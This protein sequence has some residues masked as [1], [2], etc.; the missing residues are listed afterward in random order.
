MVVNQMRVEDVVDNA[1]AVVN[2]AKDTADAQDPEVDTVDRTTYPCLT[3]LKLK[4]YRTV[5]PRLHVQS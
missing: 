5:S 4:Q 1:A 2:T 3:L